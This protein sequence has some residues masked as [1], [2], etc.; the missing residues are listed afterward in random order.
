VTAVKLS[1]TGLLAVLAF[2]P[3]SFCFE[4]A[5]P[6]PISEIVKRSVAANASDW[7]AQP[8][9][10]H[11][12]CDLKSKTD[13]NGQVHM[14]QSKTYEITMLDGSPYSRL[15]EI[16][17]HALTRDQQ[18]Q[19]QAKLNAEIRRR[20]NQPA[21]ERQARISKYQSQRADEHVLMQQMVEAFTFTQ[22]GEAKVDG[23]DCYVLDARPN[24]AYNPPLEKARV[25]L[26]MK[27]RL[28]I[29]KEHY[30]WVKVQAEVINPVP[31]GLFVAK[32]K[33][34]TRFELEQAPAGDVWLP[35]H[36]SESVNATVFGF[37]GLRSNEDDL[38][39]DYR[40]LSAN[41][42]TGT[43]ELTSAPVTAARHA[44]PVSASEIAVR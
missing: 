6:L 31:F 44:N 33:P 37:Y 32:V 18:Q 27:G 17:G 11:R 1:A 39:S 34:G 29:D 38:Y 21:S 36:F 2:A 26:G 28:W 40:P 41:S 12:E 19:E 42:S 3:K 43:V 20:Q 9:Y 25:L 14:G 23:V 30:H 8:R 13:C 24:P 35:K 4:S 16:D 10:S 22:A 7:N 15:V 5:S